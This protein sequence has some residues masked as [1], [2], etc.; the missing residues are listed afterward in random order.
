M[1][2]KLQALFRR[3]HARMIF[4][5]PNPSP[6][7]WRGVRK[8]RSCSATAAQPELRTYDDIPKSSTF[9]DLN[10]INVHRVAQMLMKSAMKHGNIFRES[11]ELG[12]A[13]EVVVCDPSDLKIVFSAEG[14]FPFRPEGGTWFKEATEQGA[15]LGFA[16]RQVCR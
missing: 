6:A 2:G 15:P 8:F 13:E 9:T 12:T 5:G 10:D 11:I 7:I 1:A 4:A 3:V 14:K 16:K